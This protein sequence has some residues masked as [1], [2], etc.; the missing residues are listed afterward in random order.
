MRSAALVTASHPAQWGLSNPVLGM[1]EKP[2]INGAEQLQKAGGIG[3][4]PE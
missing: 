2:G 1:A 3:R 4:K